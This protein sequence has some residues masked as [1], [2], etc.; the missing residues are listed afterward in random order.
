MQALKLNCVA[1]SVLGLALALAV[2]CAA[3]AQDGAVP[4]TAAAATVPAPAPAK[5]S[6]GS[7]LEHRVELLTRELDLDGAQRLKV[8]ALLESQREQ[9]LRVWNDET[10]PGALR[11]KRTQ[12]ISEGTED[13]IRAMLTDEQKRKYA[14][15]RPAGGTAGST[16]ADLG[17]W[18][19][20]VN[21]R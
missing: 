12:V 7:A 1:R 17:T 13:S 11:V 2:G 18:M 15:P 4:D 9:V 10:V 20:K 5:P 21:G 14:K 6:R 8:K 16:S 3:A 19:D